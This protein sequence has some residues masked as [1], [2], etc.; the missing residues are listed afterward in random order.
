M[1]TRETLRWEKV[2][3]VAT[4]TLDRPRAL[5]A[6]NAAMMAE[7]EEVFTRLGADKEVQV[8]L[9]TGAGERAFVAGA[10]I[11]ELAE[12]DAVSGRAVSE[13]GQRVF[14]TVERCG[15]PVIACLNGVALG[16]GL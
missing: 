4:V 8:I 12:V 6:I 10:D 15:K 9:L 5:N 2:G 14:S 13:T 3:A 11:R 16:G 7:L 1:E